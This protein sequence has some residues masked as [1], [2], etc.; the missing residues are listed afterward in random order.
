MNWKTVA[1]LSPFACGA[2]FL[3]AGLIQAHAYKLRRRA[4]LLPDGTSIL[5]Q[6]LQNAEILQDLPPHLSN[7]GKSESDKSDSVD[8]I[9]PIHAAD[10]DPTEKMRQK[11]TAKKPKLRK[12]S[13]LSGS[14][15]FPTRTCCGR[16]FG[17]N[18]SCT[19]SLHKIRT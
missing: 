16:K 2:A 12:N 14:C 9:L 7:D 18:I 19:P 1:W 10:S 6:N 11:K 3:T 5:Q 8:G 13:H 17:A 15:I 4:I